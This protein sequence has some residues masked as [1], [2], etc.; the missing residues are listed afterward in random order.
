[1]DILS[2]FKKV[3]DGVQEIVDPINPMVSNL[4]NHKSKEIARGLLLS[5]FTVEEIQQFVDVSRS[6]LDPFLEL[7]DEVNKRMAE[8]KEKMKPT[9]KAKASA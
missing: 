5:G 6:Q 7:E 3:V 8:A 4:D 9:P 2:G 1:M